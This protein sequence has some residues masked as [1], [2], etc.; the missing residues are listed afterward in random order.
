[1]S[2][3]AP[4][5]TFVNTHAKG[6]KVNGYTF[7]TKPDISI[8]HKSLSGKLPAGCNSSMIDMHIEFKRYDWDDPFTC[9]PSLTRRDTAFISSKP[10]ETNTLGQIGAYAAAQLASQFRTHCFSVYIIHNTAHII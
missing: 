8:Y 10:N 3:F 6:D 4:Q 9:P 7:E 1:M 2:P 5:L